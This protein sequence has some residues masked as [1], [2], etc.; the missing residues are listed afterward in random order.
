MFIFLLIFLLLFS[1]RIF[2]LTDDHLTS[3]GLTCLALGMSLLILRSAFRANP[4]NIS[5]WLLLLFLTP[6][7]PLALLDNFL[8]LFR[9]IFFVPKSLHIRLHILQNSIEILNQQTIKDH[10][11]ISEGEKSVVQEQVFAHILGIDEVIWLE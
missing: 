11:L 10:D 7:T 1:D 6:L 5:L 2:D 4:A 8:R 3:W 9:L